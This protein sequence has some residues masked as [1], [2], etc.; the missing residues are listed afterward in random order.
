MSALEDQVRLGM[1]CKDHDSG[2]NIAPSTTLSLLFV[3]PEQPVMC[4]LMKDFHIH[5]EATCAKSCGYCDSPL[6]RMYLPSDL[7]D[8]EKCADGDKCILRLL[9]EIEGKSLVTV[10]AYCHL[11]GIPFPVDK[12]NELVAAWRLAQCK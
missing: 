6:A 12:F 4:P 8:D 3:Q 2:R 5:S 1:R 9:G 7:S 11:Y 10:A